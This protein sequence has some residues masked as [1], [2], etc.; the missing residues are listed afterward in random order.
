MPAASG[1]YKLLF[2]PGPCAAPLER[3]ADRTGLPMAEA[4]R[5]MIAACSSAPLFNAVFPTYSG[6]MSC[7]LTAEDDLRCPPPGS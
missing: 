7:P 4:L 2:A 1:T 5:R 6:R 3:V